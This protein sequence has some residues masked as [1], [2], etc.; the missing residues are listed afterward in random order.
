VLFARTAAEAAAEL[1]RRRERWGFT[2]ITTFASSA[3]A[4]GAVMREL[5]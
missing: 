4:L 3:D 2:C 5:R 1:E